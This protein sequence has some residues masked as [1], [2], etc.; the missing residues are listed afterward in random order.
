[1][2]SQ[3]PFPMEVMAYKAMTATWLRFQKAVMVY[4]GGMAV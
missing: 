4:K 2:A 1:M 3:S